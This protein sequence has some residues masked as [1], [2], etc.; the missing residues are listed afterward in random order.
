V[1]FSHR[2]IET[3]I[4]TGNVLSQMQ[5]S[6]IEANRELPQTWFSPPR[7]ERTPLQHFLESLYGERTDRE[8]VMWSYAE[9]RRAARGLPTPSPALATCE[10]DK[11][12][13]RP[14][15]VTIH[16]AL[17]P[18]SRIPVQ[19]TEGLLS[20]DHLKRMSRLDR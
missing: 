1:L 4:A 2:S 9:F 16:N 6:K 14:H 3:E 18:L 7:Y 12:Y 8:A 15:N 20:V 11:C 19:N 13:F 10:C 5:W 17:H